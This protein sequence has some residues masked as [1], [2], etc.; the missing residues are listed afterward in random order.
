MLQTPSKCIITYKVNSTLVITIEKNYM[1]INSS[2]KD[3][4]AFCVAIV[5]YKVLTIYQ[6]NE[7]SAKYESLEKKLKYDVLVLALRQI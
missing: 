3:I 7:L 4:D 5:S 6:I 1:I 2:Q